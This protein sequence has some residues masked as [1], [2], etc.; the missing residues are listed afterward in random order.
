MTGQR[1]PRYS[2]W[3]PR[4]GA[5][6]LD[7]VIVWLIALV[8]ILPTA[9]ITAGSDSDDLSGIVWLLLWLIGSVGYIGGTMTRKGKHNGQTLGKQTVGIRVTRDDGKPVGWGTVAVREVLMKFVVW[10][11]TFGIGWLADILW[12]LGE[13]EKRA[14]HDLIV[15]THV[16]DT[17]AAPARPQIQAPPWGPPQPQLAPAIAR[18]VYAAQVI[19][20]RIGETIQRAQLPYTE[21]CQEVESLVGLMNRSAH[22]APLLHEALADTPVA[23]IEERL[24]QLQGS[25]KTELIG[26]L[27]HQLTV[28]RRMQTQLERYGDELERIVVELDTVRGN[29]LSVSAS[30]DV[31]NQERLAEQVRS[32]RDEMSS[33]AEGVSVAYD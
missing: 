16:E 15:S 6:L 7:T 9:A 20:A 32:L 5:W 19:Q 18:H 26:S 14:L 3:W 2:D 23:R 21:V 22:R 10:N 33:V 11:A 27:E 25:G 31:A 1:P 17:K 12:P 30:T 8:V 29:L 24:G 4:A 28:Q 13:R